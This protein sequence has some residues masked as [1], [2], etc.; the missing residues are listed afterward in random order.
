MLV[1]PA[2]EMPLSRMMVAGTGTRQLLRPDD[3]RH[4]M[5]YNGPRPVAARSVAEPHPGS[6]LPMDFT[7]KRLTLR[8]I[9]LADMEP[10]Y[11]LYR[12]PL[13]MRYIIGRPRTRAE[14]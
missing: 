4:V 10:L 5:R 7:T 11:T 12:D 2:L 1:L 9:T 13:L 8:P 6:Q 3:T 14:T